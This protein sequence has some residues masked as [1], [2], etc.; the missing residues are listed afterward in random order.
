MDH[1]FI[2]ACHDCDLIHRV[3]SVPEGHVARCSRCNAVLYHHKRNSLDRAL[4]LTFAGLILFVIA[5]CYP[6]LGFKIGANIRQ[7]SLITGCEELFLQGKWQL[8]SVV[9]FTTILIP[10]LQ[11]LGLLYVLVPLKMNRVPRGLGG[12]FRFIGHLG[13]WAMMEV[14]MLGILVSLVKLA[15]MA[16]IVPGISVYAFMALIFVLAG[17]IATLDPHIIWERIKYRS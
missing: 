16:T 1:S 14:F 10:G 5:N 3:E 6:F 13:P 7:T 11:L 4:A 15:K 9:L 17:S 8:A 12:I 2:I